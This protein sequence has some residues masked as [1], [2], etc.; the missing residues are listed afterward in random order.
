[1]DTA[2]KRNV[3][4]EHAVIYYV[5]KKITENWN[6]TCESLNITSTVI[7]QITD[8]EVLKSGGQTP[9]RVDEFDKV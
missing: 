7:A 8:D 1:M 5:P 3:I 2:S 4:G 9:R 6:E